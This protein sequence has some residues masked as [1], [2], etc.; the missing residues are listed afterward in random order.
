MHFRPFHLA[1][2]ALTLLFASQAAFAASDGKSVSP[3]VCQARG[4]GT[5]ASELTFGPY[6]ITNPGTTNETVIC[7]LPGDSDVKWSAIAGGSAYVYVFYR[8]GAQTGTVACTAFTS[9]AAVTANAT[10]SVSY[11]ATDIPANTRSNFQLNLAEAGNSY[12]GA[13]PAV[14]VCTLSPKTALGWMYFRETEA[15][16]AP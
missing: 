9:T 5:T 13:P 14:V 2:T 7:P 3:M 1:L 11:S 12:S 8:T 6:G 10:Y 4:P 15:T 16:D